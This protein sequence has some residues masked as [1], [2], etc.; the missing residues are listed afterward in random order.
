MRSASGGKVHAGSSSLLMWYAM[1]SQQIPL[2]GHDGQL[3]VQRVRLVSFLHSIQPVLFIEWLFVRVPAAAPVFPVACP[4]PG[5][6]S[7]SSM[8]RSLT[9]NE[10]EA[11]SG[12]PRSTIYY[13]VREGLLPTAQK[14]AASRAIYTDHHVA[15]LGDITRLKDQGLPLRNIRERLA[16]RIVA[17]RATDVDLVAEQNE[18][19]RRPSSLP[20]PGCSFAKGTSARA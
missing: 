1:Q 4:W 6:V 15:L 12:V 3:Q 19:T 17:A 20:P 11:A 13:Y 18:Q 8:M 5:P 14:A 7:S 16:P 9:I 10:L 2:R